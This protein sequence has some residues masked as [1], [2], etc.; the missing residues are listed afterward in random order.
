M[1][2]KKIISALVVGAAAAG[3]ATADLAI[4]SNF[5]LS[6]NMFAYN[7]DNSGEKGTKKKTLFDLPGQA[8]NDNTTLT[9]K[10]NIF[11]FETILVPYDDQYD[12]AILLKKMTVA[13]NVG[14]F[15]FTTGWNRDGLRTYDFN[16]NI[17]ALDEGRI[18]GTGFKLGS[19]FS[20]SPALFVNNQQAIGKDATT[21]FVHGKYAL[22][23]GDSLTLNIAA[24]AMSPHGIKKSHMKGEENLD[25]N[26][27]VT[28][29][30]VSDAGT[31]NRKHEGIA[32]G[33]FLNPVLKG[34]VGFDVFAK[35]WESNSNTAKEGY[36]F[37][38]GGYANLLAVPIMNTALLGGSVYLSDEVGHMHLNEWNVD[39]SLGFKLGDKVQLTFNNKFAF[40]DGGGT[41]GTV[42]GFGTSYANEYL[43]WDIL[44]VS[45]QLN[46][47]FKLI[48]TVGHESTFG[49]FD[50]K[51]TTIFVYPHAQI[52]ASSAA[53]VSAG[54]VLTLDKIGGH[55]LIG[56][57]K[58]AIL[59]N[60]P[61]V[62]RVAL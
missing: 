42:I 28:E 36:N 57:D 24:S 8:V 54:A 20:S 41:A 38:F 19:G 5:K 32:W 1:K 16:G 21:Y 61:V 47:T 18:K 50:T 58:M 11:T 7:T 55:S 46:D 10:G 53:S 12:Q 43:L 39:L 34:I 33:V 35:G 14:N 30:T 29:N 27:H 62:V 23:L 49:K 6:S 52:F 22:G 31:G 37:L 48:G 51:G 44:G 40:K 15:T 17:D 26:G 3:I 25:T 45:F 9:A 13:A 59:V 2:M 56:S 60:V 4:K